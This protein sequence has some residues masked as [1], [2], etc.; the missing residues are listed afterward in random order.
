MRYRDLARDG[1]RLP[2]SH[3]VLAQL[4]IEPADWFKFERMIDEN[5]A[6][7]LLGHDEPLDGML[8]TYVACASKETRQRL[9][10]G[11]C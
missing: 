7:R 6:T 5:P 10:D 4:D 2:S 11:W 3:P 1:F 8:T 9:E